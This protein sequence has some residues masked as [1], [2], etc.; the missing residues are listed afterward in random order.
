M[1]PLPEG[2]G[3]GEGEGGLQLSGA[4]RFG[5]RGVLFCFVHRPTVIRQRMQSASLQR[6]PN[7]VGD[8]VLLAPQAGV[9]ESKHL[10][11]TGFQSLAV[12]QRAGVRSVSSPSPRLSP[13]RGRT[14]RCAFDNPVRLESSP[15]GMGCSLS[16][17]ARARVG[18]PSE[19]APPLPAPLLSPREERENPALCPPYFP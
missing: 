15:R 16:L 8:G 14:V 18:N 6:P 19:N 4:R 2:E 10:D 1:F 12:R 7:R 5:R 9:P 11:A 13:R 17:R 3:Q